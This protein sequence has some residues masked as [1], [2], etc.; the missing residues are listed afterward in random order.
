MEEIGID[1]LNGE[2]KKYVPD[3]ITGDMDSSVGTVVDKLK[4][5]G[6]IVIETPDQ[7]H[8]DFTKALVQVGQ[9]AKLKNINVIA[10]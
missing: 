7:D 6:S 1:V 5:F 3:L 10:L 8:T 9:Y 2:Y 4:S